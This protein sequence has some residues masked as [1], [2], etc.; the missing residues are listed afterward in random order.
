MPSRIKSNIMS[1]LIIVTAISSFG[2]ALWQTLFVIYLEKKGLSYIT[3]GLSSSI[4]FII[5]A[6]L[7]LPA[8]I[9]CDSVNK[10]MLI[11]I[12]LIINSFIV[13]TIP[14]VDHHILLITLILLY[15]FS[16]SFFGQTAI[17]LVAY[18]SSTSH[19]ATA[20]SLYYLAS[21]VLGTLGTFI[22]GHL[23]EEFGYGS[24]YILGASSYIIS[25]IVAM[26]FLPLI[27]LSNSERS[28]NKS[29]DKLRV[30]LRRRRQ[31]KL[32]IATLV[33]HDCASFIA[34]PFI[35]LFAKDILLL[36]ESVISSLLGLRNISQMISQ[37]ISGRLA[38]R[39]GGSKLLALHIALIC[40]LYIAYSYSRG[41]VDVMILMVLFGFT[42][43]LD[44]PSRR[45]LLSIYA[46][47][48]LVATTNGLAD[49]LV[50]FGSIASPL[51]GGYLWQIGYKRGVFFLAGLANVMALP[52][53][54]MLSYSKYNEPNSVY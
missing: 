48:D 27:P 16:I 2:S 53:I 3:I 30:L 36:K 52:F 54:I 42:F 15:G 43:S 22:S 10:K 40:L 19:R 32:L 50:G 21:Q 5:P 11:I 13:F 26:L 12:S 51:I 29:I 7:A 24:V 34:V 25:A 1:T 6:I 17:S 49:T 23:V 33:L 47:E 9:V 14:L 18:S 45:A 28:L 35:V 41:I 39:I 20:Y 31:L 4:F 8:G 44:M 38:D 46:S 37:V